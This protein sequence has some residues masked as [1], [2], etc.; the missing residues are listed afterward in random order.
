MYGP[1]VAAGRRLCLQ[2]K[3]RHARE[4]GRRERG[5]GRPQQRSVEEVQA[6]HT[7]VHRAQIQAVLEGAGEGGSTICL[8]GTNGG[9]HQRDAPLEL[10]E[11]S[12]PSAICRSGGCAA[13]PEGARARRTPSPLCV[14]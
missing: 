12:L 3:L 14:N 4:E 5:P 10:R 8:K 7:D 6:L 13:Q 9:G 11:V 1:L 2:D